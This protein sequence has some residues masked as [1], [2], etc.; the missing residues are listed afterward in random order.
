[1][2]Q[3]SSNVKWIQ[4]LAIIEKRINKKRIGISDLNPLSDLKEK[5][6]LFIDLILKLISVDN[7]IK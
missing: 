7:P 6:P 2:P 3:S 5:D 4:N 1:M